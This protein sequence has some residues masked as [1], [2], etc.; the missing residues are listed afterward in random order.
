MLHQPLIVQLAP[1]QRQDGLAAPQFH[2][3]LSRAL[4]QLASLHALAT[5][6]IMILPVA[7]A[8]MT[9]QPMRSAIQQ[10]EPSQSASSVSTSMVPLRLARIAV[11]VKSVPTVSIRPM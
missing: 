11:Q 5:M 4:T 6:S 1:T 9:A 2:T 7:P 10:Q 3:A 8:K